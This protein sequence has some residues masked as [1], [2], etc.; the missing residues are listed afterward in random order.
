MVAEGLAGLYVDDLKTG[1]I[2]FEV[3]TKANDEWSEDDVAALPEL[4]MI[5]KSKTSVRLVR[6]REQKLS[7]LEINPSYGGSC[8]VLAQSFD[9]LTRKEW[10]ERHLLAAR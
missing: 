1:N 7:L 3:V 9:L 10:L 8:L 6:A 5:D 2:I 4:Q